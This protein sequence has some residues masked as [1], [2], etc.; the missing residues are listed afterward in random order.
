VDQK[1]LEVRKRLRD[2]FPFYAKNC[3]K[4]RTKDGDVIPF[5]PLKPAQERLME[6]I[7]EQEAEQGY[8]RILILKARQQGLSTV[9]GGWMFSKVSQRTGAKAL[10]MAHKRDSTD[11]I[12]GMVRRFYDS[13]PEAMKPSTRYASKRELFFDKLDSA[14]IVATAGGDGVARGETITHFHGSEVAFYPKSTARELWNGVRQSIADKPGTAIF[15]ESTA[16]GCTG[17]FFEMCQLALKGELP[18]WK[19]VF[20]PWFMDSEYRAEELPVN[21]RRRLDEDEIAQ[22]FGLDDHQLAWRRAKIAETSPEQFKQEYPATA[23]EAFLTSGL[24]VFNPEQLVEMLRDTPDPQVID[25]REWEDEAWLAHSRG[26]LKVYHKP[27]PAESYVVGADV[28]KGI[29]GADYSVAQVLDTKKRLVASWRGHVVSDEF[30]RILKRIGDW[31]N[32]A[33]ICVE[34][35]DHGVLTGYVLHKELLYPNLYI[36][37]QHDKEN[38]RETEVIGF[39]TNVR[40]RP[41]VLD[42]LRAAMRG[43]DLDIKDRDTLTEMMTFV[44]NEAGKMEADEGCHDDCV[45]ALAFANYAHAGLWKPVKNEDDWYSEAYY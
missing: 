41:M 21:W 11:A 20:I 25:R 14:Y 45:M 43:K 1:L 8:V 10:V 28:G 44:L 38:E 19:I 23:E 9:V 13:L 18:G 22:K 30:A 16:Q 40:T 24:P 4:I 3:L 31:Y 27:D 42:Q 5:Y 12:F 37:I 26:R 32:T 29:K 15:L 39:S 34:N 17:V 2:D 36:T 6:A 7:Q 33:K 35:N